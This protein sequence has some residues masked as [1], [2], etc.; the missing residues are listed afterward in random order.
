M[1]HNNRPAVEF[2][3]LPAVPRF[4][5]RERIEGLRLSMR[6]YNAVGTTSIYE[7]HGVAA[8]TIAAYRALWEQGALTV[9]CGLVLSPSW[10]DVAE[11]RRAMRDWLAHARGQGLGDPWLRISGVHI[12][13]GGDA[14]VAA[15]ARANLPDTGWAGFVEQA[16]SPSDFREAAF[17]CAEHDLRLHTIVSDQLHEIVPVLEAVDARHP[18]AG[19][20]WVIEHIGRARDADLQ[21]L[22]RLGLWVTTIPTYFLWKGGHAYRDEPDGGEQVVPHRRLLALGVPLSIATDNIPYDPFFTLW[23]CVARQA[24]RGGAVI[25]PGQ[26][27]DAATALRLFT[28]EGAGL[29]FDEGWKGPLRP[30]FAAD[31]AVLSDD[32]TQVP[33][34]ALKDLRCTLTVVDGRIVHERGQQPGPTLGGM[35]HWHTG[36]CPC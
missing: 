19:R 34:Q 36:A 15:R 23:V 31:L 33:T 2:D 8:E 3:L 13:Y 29:T 17:L 20:R 32:P 10:A 12:A 6:L 14:R 27:L 11:A 16:L 4:G 24:R 30:G 25:G 18:L 21:A 7:G 9:R 28:V 5:L 35:G 1:E 26:R 22:A